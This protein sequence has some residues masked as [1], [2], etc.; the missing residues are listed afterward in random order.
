MC[1]APGKA[2]GMRILSTNPVWR[3]KPLFIVRFSADFATKSSRTRSLSLFVDDVPENA[4]VI[5]CQP[6]AHFRQWHLPGAV[7][8]SPE[9]VIHDLKRFDKRQSYV[10]YCPFGTQSAHLAEIMQ[11]CGYQA[12]ALRGGIGAIRQRHGQPEMT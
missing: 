5:D 2:R 3:M 7:N 6:P 11:Q 10:L 8:R 9:S 12:Y 1:T 4:E